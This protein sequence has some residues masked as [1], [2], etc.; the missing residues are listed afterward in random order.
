MRHSTGGGKGN[1][2]RPLGIDG[3]PEE[4]VISSTAKV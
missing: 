2:E 3:T 4:I 1:N